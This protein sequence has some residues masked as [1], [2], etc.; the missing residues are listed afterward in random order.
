MKLSIAWIFDHIDADWRQVDIQEL[1]KKFN[2]TT[3]EIEKVVPITLNFDEITLAEVIN[4]ADGAIEVFSPEWQKKVLLP[5]RKDIVVGSWYLIH[6]AHS[7]DQWLSMSHVGSS[8]DHL[9]PAVYTDPT[10]RAGLWKKQIPSTDYLLEV[11]NKSIT[12]RP[13]MWGHRGFAREIAALLGFSL[14]PLSEFTVS[15]PIEQHGHSAHHSATNPFEIE[16]KTDACSRFAG[17][18]FDSI[19][20]RPSSLAMALR[21]AQL[22]V[23]PID[24][25]VDCT[26]YVMLDISQ[27]MH[28]F[29]A[30]KLTRRMIE[31][32]KGDSEEKLLL[33]D[34]Q[35]INLTADDI[36]IT[37]G[38]KPISLAGIMGGSS[39][40]INRHTESILLEAAYFNATTIRRT[41]TRHKLRTEGSARWEKTLDPNQNIQAIGRFV[42]LLDDAGIAYHHAPSI[43]SCGKPTEPK[44]VSVSLDFLQKRLGVQLDAHTVIRILECLEFGVD[45]SDEIFTVTIPTFRGTKDVAI[46]E[47]IL[48]EVGRFYG[49]TNIAAQMPSA[50]LIP[51]DLHAVYQ[52]RK[53]KSFMT[54]AL[55]MHELENYSFY[56]E[57]F[58]RRLQWSP[59]NYISVQSPVSENWQRLVTSLIPHL[60]KAVEQ[61]N[62]D[63]NEL[64]FFEWARVWSK[65]I[66]PQEIISHERK[67]LAGIFFNK[68]E[69][70]DFYEAKALLERF[71]VAF[72]I[73]VVWRKVETST[74][75]WEAPYQTAQLV[76]RNRLIGMA[77][78][79]NSLFLDTIAQGDAFIFEI[80]GDFLL[81]YKPSL[82]RYVEPSKYPSAER[83]ISV[84]ISLTYTV[85]E[86]ISAMRAVHGTIKSVELV[87]C[88]EKKEWVNQRA[89]TFRFVMQDAQKTL[90]KDEVEQVYN[91]VAQVFKDCG[92]AIR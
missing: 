92:A 10:L 24:A 50:Q 21:L 61:N 1:A 16:I 58:L 63:H 46:K 79:V 41:A 89:L 11:D 52:R 22:E 47:D 8:K 68:K 70:V 62:I 76:H 38:N 65:E 66:T 30:D 73:P 85:D 27:P 4:S 80:D 75:P 35:E 37:D 59:A 72:D 13:D 56:D 88:F 23:K 6:R 39:T 19:E 33:L 64:R 90:T 36:V 55:Q 25:I 26:N 53:A 71:F 42:R 34:G 18:F 51:A 32:R 74:Y 57:D 7:G 2:A 91:R 49:Y 87:D 5:T 67:V 84:L 45:Y 54:N 12:H 15:L 69:P 9:F 82:K 29:D 77:G 3:A 20:R 43:A 60:F 17:L 81:Q 28:A 83:D 44:T 31:I 48:E 78:K 86:L 14:K 40:S